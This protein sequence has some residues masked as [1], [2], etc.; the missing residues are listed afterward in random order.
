MIGRDFKPL[1]RKFSHLKWNSSIRLQ[2]ILRSGIYSVSPHR[3][4]KGRRILLYRPGHWDTSAITFP[5][6]LTLTDKHQLKLFIVDHRHLKTYIIFLSVLE[7]FC[8]GLSLIEMLSLEPKT[9]I[10]GY[11]CVVDGSGLRFEHMR[12][13]SMRDIKNCSGYMQVRGIRVVKRWLWIGT[14]KMGLQNEKNEDLT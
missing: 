5:G 8:S 11:I 12:A 9:Q 2:E 10:G 14:C 6:I 3:D 4:S 13:Y 1:S 7:I